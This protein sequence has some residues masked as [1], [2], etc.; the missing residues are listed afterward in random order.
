M[1]PE[2]HDQPHIIPGNAVLLV[3]LGSLQKSESH[4][5]WLG[6]LPRRADGGILDREY[7]FLIQ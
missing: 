7:L 1:I 5:L 6:W 3:F 2:L 4:P